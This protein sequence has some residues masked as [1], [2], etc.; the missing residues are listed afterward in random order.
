MTVVK[1]L[2]FDC[3]WNPGGPNTS[4]LQPAAHGILEQKYFVCPGIFRWT[5]NLCNC[6]IKSLFYFKIQKE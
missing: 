1:L 2:G 4:V 5:T 3:G 6:V